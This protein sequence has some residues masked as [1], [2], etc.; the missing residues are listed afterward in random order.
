MRTLTLSR[1]VRDH[2]PNTQENLFVARAFGEYAGLYED[3]EPKM[4]VTGRLDEESLGTGHFTAF[5][6][7][8][9]VFARPL[10]AGDAGRRAQVRLEKSGDGQLYYGARLTYSPAQL[11]EAAVNAGFEVAREYRVKRDGKWLPLSGDMTLHTG[12]VVKIDLYAAL[13]AERYFVVL[14]DPVPGGLEPL[15][16]DLATTSLEDAD[17]EDEEH[18]DSFDRPEDIPDRWSFYHR[19]L[20][21]D[22]VRFYAERLAAGRY[23]L[24]YMAQAIAPGEF[25][26]LPV[27]AE[28]MYSPDIYG[29]GLP[30]RLK[31][32]AAE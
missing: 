5:G 23:H 32:E 18:P 4:T 28:E 20:R 19:E 9:L 21:H 7:P 16:R 26:V 3:Q 6:D 22:A 14:E 25:Q 8:P 13:P 31:I 24:S 10:A 17:G 11:P 30:A 29:N 2:W 12:E 27:H 15:D 1:K